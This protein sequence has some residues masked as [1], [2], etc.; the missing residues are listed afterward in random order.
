MWFFII[1][2]LI[3]CCSTQ[4]SF[5]SS[6][7]SVSLF[8]HALSNVWWFLIFCSHSRLRI[9]TCWLGLICFCQLIS[10]FLDWAFREP[11][12]KLPLGYAGWEVSF[13]MLITA[14]PIWVSF[15]TLYTICCICLGIN[16]R[17]LGFVNGGG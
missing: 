12:S 13:L 7:F 15:H 1:L 14:V 17:M 3:C 6:R 4:I 11:A 16:T 2:L 5:P 8:L 10:F 9:L